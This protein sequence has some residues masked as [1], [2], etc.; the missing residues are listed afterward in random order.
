MDAQ[1]ETLPNL[2]TEVQYITSLLFKLP[3]EKI[4]EVRDYTLFLHAR[5]GDRQTTVAPF[6]HVSLPSVTPTANTTIN[7]DDA[8]SE[9]DQ[10]DLAASSFHYAQQLLEIEDEYAPETR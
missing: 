8:W 3:L 1:L 9:E 7:V 6:F 2:E 4:V 5:Y 10:H